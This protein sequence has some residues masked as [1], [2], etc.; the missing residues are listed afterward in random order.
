MYIGTINFT[1]IQLFAALL[2][3]INY[4]PYICTETNGY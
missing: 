4:Y 3:N 1:F 2:A